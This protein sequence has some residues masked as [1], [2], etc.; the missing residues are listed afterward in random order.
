MGWQEYFAKFHNCVEP[1]WGN[2]PL[3]QLI[4]KEL[5]DRMSQSFWT[6]PQSEIEVELSRN[7]VDVEE[8]EAEPHE[9]EPAG[10]LGQLIDAWPSLDQALDK[11]IA[12]PAED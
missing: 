6:P 11:I 7:E 2:N 4:I 9:A 5:S 3:L 1:N 12:P 8:V 10:H